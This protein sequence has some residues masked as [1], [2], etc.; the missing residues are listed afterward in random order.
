MISQVEVERTILV[1]AVQVGSTVGLDVIVA[2]TIS[3]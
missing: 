3:L 1:V 2:S